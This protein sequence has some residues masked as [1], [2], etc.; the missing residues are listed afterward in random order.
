MDLPIDFGRAVIGDNPIFHD[1]V[2][3]VAAQF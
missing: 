3:R 2:G 1:K